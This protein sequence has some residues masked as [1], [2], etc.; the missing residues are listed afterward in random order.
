MRR[1]QRVVSFALA[2]ATGT[3]WNAAETTTVFVAVETKCVC[4]RTG[5]SLRGATG[6]KYGNHCARGIISNEK[7]ADV[8]GRCHNTVDGT[9]YIPARRHII[10]MNKCTRLDSDQVPARKLFGFIYRTASNY[11]IDGRSA[12]HDS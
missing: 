12:H 9:D 2:C 1:K 5:E 6:S 11:M 4:V 8:F 3:G 10:V 7:L